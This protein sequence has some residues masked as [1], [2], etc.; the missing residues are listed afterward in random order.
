MVVGV[1]KGFGGIHEV[2]GVA[3]V[4]QPLCAYSLR[5]RGEEGLRFVRG[6]FKKCGRG[7]DEGDGILP[8]VSGKGP[9]SVKGLRTGGEAVVVGFG[10]EQLPALLGGLLGFVGVELVASAV[11]VVRAVDA[12]W[13]GEGPGVF[14]HDGSEGGLP[15]D[16]ELLFWGE[17]QEHPRL[18][19]G[20]VVCH[21]RIWLCVV[22]VHVV[23]EGHDEDVVG[24]EYLF[25]LVE[26]DGKHEPCID[27]VVDHGELKLPAKKRG[28]DTEECGGACGDDESGGCD[29]SGQPCFFGVDVMDPF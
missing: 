1:K 19:G 16:E 13:G 29:G 20:D 8:A 9:Q 14:V 25:G 15:K 23:L 17:G 21:L 7:Q 22:E 2:V 4:G 24:P 18:V 28:V 5:E 3:E 12:D 11:Y 6:V 27:R 26:D 10:G